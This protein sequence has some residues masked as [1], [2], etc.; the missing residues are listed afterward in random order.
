MD[1]TVYST[2]DSS[3]AF[4]WGNERGMYASVHVDSI[5]SQGL[6]KKLNPSLP[7][8]QALLT[9]CLSGVFEGVP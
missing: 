3:G 8:G 5:N 4:V 2:Q 9:F 6:K 7:F 1:V